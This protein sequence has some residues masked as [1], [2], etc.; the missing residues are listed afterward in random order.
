VR[1]PGWF[2]GWRAT[3]RLLL[4]DRA[5]LRALRTAELGDYGLVPEPLPHKEESEM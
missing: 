2:W 1:L 4:F 5:T 3:F